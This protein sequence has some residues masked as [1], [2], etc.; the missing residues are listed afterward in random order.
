VTDLALPLLVN[1][2]T[3]L[4]VKVA[5]SDPRLCLA[6]AWMLLVLGRPGAVEAEVRAAERGVLQGR[7]PTDR[8]RSSRAPRWSE[9]RPSRFSAT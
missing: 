5:E 3:S 7:W 1:A 2:L 6:R 8:A 4:P 9:P